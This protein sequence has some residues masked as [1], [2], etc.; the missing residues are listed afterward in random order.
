M[1]ETINW[2]CAHIEIAIAIV[3]VLALVFF[4]WEA[5]ND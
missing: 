1:A 5:G 2:I 4:V 3:Y